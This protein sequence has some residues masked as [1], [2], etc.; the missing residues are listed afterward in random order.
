MGRIW[1]LCLAL[2]LGACAAETPTAPLAEA[3]AVTSFPAR[4]SAECHD[5]R[6]RLYDECGSQ[7][8]ILDSALAEARRS[9]KTV[10]INFGAEWCIWCHVF[11][12]HLRGATGRIQYPVE[13]EP[14]TLIERSGRS[15]LPD[16]KELNDYAATHLVI[17]HIEVEQAP[18]GWDVMDRTGARKAFADELPFVVAVTPEGRFAAAMNAKQAEVRRDSG[19]DWYRGYDRKH[20]LGELKRMRQKAMDA[21]PR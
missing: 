10:V 4:L 13:R 14:V 8:A 16:A 3:R 20:L 21:A 9:G 17:A 19:D 18:D 1:L 12:A 5:G 11:D 6:A 2:V 15:V 7:A